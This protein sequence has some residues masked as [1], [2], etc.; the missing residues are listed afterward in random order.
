[1]LGHKEAVGRLCFYRRA[2]DNSAVTGPQADR[3]LIAAVGVHD[4]PRQDWSG[5]RSAG[6]MLRT[7]VP[8]LL[9][10]VAIYR[11]HLPTRTRDNDEISIERDA[12][13][14]DDDGCVRRNY[15]LPKFRAVAPIDR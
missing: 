12:A 9:I 7:V 10:G 5:N 8:R 11:P 14:E 15:S 6:G 1:M 2:P 13:V 3:V 4:V